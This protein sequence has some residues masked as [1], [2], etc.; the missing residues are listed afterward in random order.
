MNPKVSVIIA[1][2]NRSHLISRA[3]QSILN[4]TY[5]NIEVIIADG[6]ST[7]NTKEVIRPYL[8]DQRVRY[9]YKKDKGPAEGRNNGIEI[10]KGKYIAILDS[11]DFWCD[12]KKLEKQ[13]RFLE[14]HPDYVLVGGGAIVLDEKG[15]ECFRILPPETNEKIRKLMLFYC[16]FPH[17]TVVFRK[18]ICKLVGGYSGFPEDW[19]LW[20]QFGKFGRFYNF[21][22]YFLCY[23]RGKQNRTQYIDRQQCIRLCFGLRKRYRNVYPNFWKAYLFGLASYFYSFFPFQKWFHRVMPKLKNMFFHHQIYQKTQKDDKRQRN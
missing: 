15:R 3:I 8:Q 9:L 11:D 5:K 20:L 2:Y 18:R 13:V 14:E 4:Q 12:S 21:Q 23:L 10:S 16:L 6:G 17:G 22:E 1:T 19:E 7:D